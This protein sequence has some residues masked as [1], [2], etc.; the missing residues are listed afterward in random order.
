MFSCVVF[1]IYVHLYIKSFDEIIIYDIMLFVMNYYFQPELQSNI[2][3]LY[4]PS[5]PVILWKRYII[6]GRW[7]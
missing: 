4:I 7:L 2:D 6:L 1:F 3:L 5:C